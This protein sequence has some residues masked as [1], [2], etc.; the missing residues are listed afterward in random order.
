MSLPILERLGRGHG[1]VTASAGTGKTHFLEQLVLDEVAR[2]QAL[3]RIL[4]VTYTKLG[5]LELKERIRGALQGA[6][7]GATN[8]VRARRQLERATLTTIHGF[9]QQA[10]KDEAFAVGRP[11]QP[12]LAPAGP[13]GARAF[14][15]ALRKGLAGPDAT[16]WSQELEQLGPSGLEKAIRK[17]LPALGRME[18]S[19]QG[20][21]VRVAPFR[22]DALYMELAQT[23][24]AL[25]NAGS[26]GAFDRF[27]EAVLAARPEVG[28]A[29]AFHRAAQDWPE[30]KGKWA[31]AIPEATRRALH[32][33]T[34]FNTEAI[35]L[36]P[37]A[38]AVARELEAIKAA[39]GLVDFED[40]IRQLRAA[41]EGPRGDQLAEN[42][43]GRFDLC[44]L[45][46][47]QD[48]SE[49]QWAILWRLFETKRLVLVG[50]AKQAIFS[51]QG[52]DLPAFLAARNA[53]R[54]A[55]GGEAS[56][57]DNWRSTREMVEA[58]N[59][60]LGLGT[61]A[62]MLIEPADPVQAFTRE[63]LARAKAC[64]A[65]AAWEDPMPAVVALPVPFRRTK[66]E[67][68]LASARVLADALLALKQAGPRFRGRGEK[69][70]QA[71]VYSDM[72]VIVRNK[73]DAELVAEELREAGVPFVQHKGRGLFEG[74]AAADLH[75]LFRALA[76]PRDPAARMRAFLTPFFGLSLAEAQGARE[77]AE[78]DPR[79]RQLVEWSLLAREGRAAALFDRVIGGGA[80]ARLLAE[81]GGQRRVADLLHLMELLQEAAGPGDG[82]AD[83]ARLLARWK[84]DKERPQGEEES[85]RRLEQE[86]DAVRILTFHAAKGLQ[87]PVVAIFGGLGEG[88][89]MGLQVQPFHRSLGSGWERRWWVGD[90]ASAPDE[91]AP[92]AEARAEERRLLYVGLTRAEGLL[93]LPVHEQPG[94]DEKRPVGK[95]V[96][97]ADWMP[98][99]PYGHLQR[100]V[101]AWRD[102]APWLH[103]GLP[104]LPE[105]APAHAPAPVILP[106]PFPFEAT[107][108]AA[109][110]ARVE[111]F[112][113]LHRRMEADAGARD[114]EPDR[115]LRTEGIPG[116]TATGVALHAMLETADLSGFDPNFRAWWTDARRDIIERRCEAAGLDRRWAEDAARLVH[117]GLGT[118][119]RLPNASPVAFAALD[120]ARTLREL[121]F[122]AATTGGRLTGALDALFEHEGRIFL[123]DWK[124][125]RLPDYA[126][127]SIAACVEEDYRLQVKVYT[128][129]ALR[130]LR[131]EDEAA[132]EA[133]FGGAIYVFL[134]GLPE[135]GQWSE[136][137]S[138]RETRAWA[139]ELEAMLERAHA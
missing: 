47:A 31:D 17:L 114:P 117:A 111:S 3:D 79:M 23:R 125:N 77:L 124:S 64:P 7:G 54:D 59:D 93:I 12:D 74:D 62:P 6:T 85:T 102:R 98:K 105:P 20:L 120:P 69:E 53:M 49:D 80:V 107:R 136:R 45:D 40:L 118:P 91:V 25:T 113:S 35:R 61:D 55:G 15:D 92:R 42:L 50:D 21:E 18:P 76:D 29:A 95:T 129:A 110:P 36:R 1:A 33:L 13:L 67:A 16:R 28:D 104:P 24:N 52:G 41:L 26:R 66:G 58:C 43:S 103:W 99:G 121:D 123:L 9:C 89:G 100:A 86:G 38:E 138:W 94:P 128:L 106:A 122:L 34:D 75:A 10:L 68:G 135:G 14:R 39:E 46:E 2:G 72:F 27:L 127:A 88:G 112:T 57:T 11:F 119:L 60:L 4:I 116:G 131:I 90:P 48:T 19:E 5:A 70:A 71:V 81:P 8:L 63:D 96:F 132:Y 115:V 73:D 126:P 44:L 109:W 97:D 133:R 137:P 51:F 130:F 134:R 30:L 22:T 32:R 56:L 139:T 83:H 84:E 82:P 108:A 78:A 101:L 65:P 87:A 37:L